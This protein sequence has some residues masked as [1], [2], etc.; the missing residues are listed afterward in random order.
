M[1]EKAEPLENLIRNWRTYCTEENFIGIGSSRKVYKVGERVIKV[2]LH[3]IGKL[4]SQN[5]MAI[6]NEI[7]A[8][9]LAPLFAAVHFV[10]ERISIQSYYRPILRRDNQSFEIDGDKDAIWIPDRYE[11]ALLELDREFDCFDLK[12]SDNYGLNDQGKL[13][14]IDYGMSKS[15]YENMWVPLA[16]AGVLP[17]IEFDICNGCGEKKELRMYGEEDQDKRCYSCGKE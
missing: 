10:D 14:F 5:E 7:E 3:P 11:D 15:L 4:Q 13:V 8:K 9:G 1:N 6:Y 17:Q 2:H 12:D 16:E